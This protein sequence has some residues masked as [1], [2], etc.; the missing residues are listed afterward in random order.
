MREERQ[1]DGEQL[2]NVREDWSERKVR[3]GKD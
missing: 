1:E 2:R 3:G